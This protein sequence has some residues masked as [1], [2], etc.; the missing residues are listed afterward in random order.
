MANSYLGSFA[1]DRYTQSSRQD[2]TIDFPTKNHKTQNTH[3]THTN[4]M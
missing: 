1:L 4:T 2:V 3:T